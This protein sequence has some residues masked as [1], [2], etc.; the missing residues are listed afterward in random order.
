MS[1]RV[2]RTMRL[3]ALCVALLLVVSGGFVRADEAGACDAGDGSCQAP[4]ETPQI[5]NEA[6][7][8]EPS[9]VAEK[10]ELTAALENGKANAALLARS[11]AENVELKTQLDTALDQT[12]QW[13][14]KAV[15]FEGTVNSLRSQAAEIEQ[16]SSGLD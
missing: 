14:T 15:E 16:V 10:K 11:N 7:P 1:L 8:Q 3:S 2:H 4:V 6:P 13:Q 12:K 5:V 9:C